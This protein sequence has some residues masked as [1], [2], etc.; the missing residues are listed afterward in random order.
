[1]ADLD[2]VNR[3][4]AWR[5]LPKLRD[6]PAAIHGVSYEPGLE[7]IDWLPWLDFL[8]WI[9]PGGESRQKG[10]APRPFPIAGAMRAIEQTKRGNA[11]WFSLLMP[12][13]LMLGLTRIGVGTATGGAATGNERHRR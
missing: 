2:I 12:F 9:I 1:M 10:H 8:R 4:E 5:D 11:A 6:V 13:P 7:V 3:Q